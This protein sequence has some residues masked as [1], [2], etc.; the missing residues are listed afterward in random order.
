MDPF[1]QYFDG[2][3]C[4]GDKKRP[5]TNF[6]GTYSGPVYVYDLGSIGIRVKQMKRALPTADLYYAM[7]ANSNLDVL[8]AIKKYGCGVDVVSLGE[9][10]RA[11]EA[12]FVPSDI[13][14]SGVAKTEKEISQALDLSIHQFNIESIP[15]LLRV[16]R[17]AKENDLVA[18]V[19]LRLNPNIDI[20][21][22]P[23]IATG[24]HENKFG[25]ELSLLPQIE[26]VL[27]DNS[28]S[29]S[30]VG[31]SLHLGSQMLEFSGFRQA[32]QL[33]VPIYQRLQLSYPNL[34]NF[35]IGG[36]LGIYYQEMDLQKEN[37]L[38]REY[39]EVVK[40]ELGKIN[41]RVQSEPGRW[42]VAHSGV[43]LTQIQ[44]VKET[45]LKSF[46][47]MDSGMNHLLRPALYDAYHSIIP[48]F[49][50]SGRPIKLYDVVGP[51]CESSD[52]FAKDRKLPEIREG[53]FLII[54]D[55]GAYGFSMAS[56]YNLQEL[57]KEVCI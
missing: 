53:E 29:L 2:T 6:V 47:V 31:I 26:K 42:L 4:F 32:L 46:L 12:G 41:A 19:A 33:L 45:T 37:S 43:L 28:A 25:M 7:K 14:F 21:T 10:H 51:I 35:D 39:A 55:A 49:H 48:L 11:L 56:Q 1:L 3:L 15:E 24:L 44:Y 18:P 57:P 30:L 16:A 17:L 34:R 27:K 40:D 54:A 52:F 5:L 22:H 38:L 13:V 9:I 23:F 20:K 50:N 36:G 8:S